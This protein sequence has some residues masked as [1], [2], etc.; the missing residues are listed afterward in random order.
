[1]KK[2]LHIC[3]LLLLLL[4]LGG[5][6]D[7]A[8][9]EGKPREPVGSVSPAAT[10]TGTE[11]ERFTPTPFRTEPTK[12]PTK[13]PTPTATVQYFNRDLTE[14]EE[15]EAG[16]TLW[17]QW[18]EATYRGAY[19]CGC[20]LSGSLGGGPRLAGVSNASVDGCLPCLFYLVGGL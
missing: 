11:A 14:S 7:D 4:C 1:M 12:E 3:I 15:I 9:E 19:Y 18:G 2:Y 20:L 10:P 13:A 16:E 6:G 5:C 8:P 17:A